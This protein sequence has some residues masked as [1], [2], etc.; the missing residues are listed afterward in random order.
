MKVSLLPWVCVLASCALLVGCGGP[1]DAAELELAHTSGAPAES[2]S[3]EPRAIEAAPSAIVAECA[4][5]CGEQP[6][7][8]EI[9][10]SMNGSSCRLAL[11]ANDLTRSPRGVRFDCLELER[12]PNGYD[13][14]EL[15][16]VTL[17]GDTCE[18]AKSGGPH[19]LAVILGCAPPPAP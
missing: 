8:G 14:D 1:A 2:E 10:I 18:A 15:G 13:Y 19:R 7:C 16:H 3:V 9:C 11:T 4:N 12:G 17:T 5:A 6:P